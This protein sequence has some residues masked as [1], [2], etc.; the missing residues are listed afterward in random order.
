MLKPPLH[1]KDND[2][3]NIYRPVR[4]SCCPPCCCCPPGPQ[5]KQGLHGLPGEP[6]K[7]GA[8]GEQGPQGKQGPAGEPGPAGLPGTQGPQG[9][10]GY[11]GQ[12]GPPLTNEYC[13]LYALE[14]TLKNHDCV[15]FKVG[16]NSSAV[17]ISPDSKEI[18]M[19]YA[20]IYYIASAWSAAG[21]GALSMALYL[22]GKKIPNM[23]YIL[24][25]A[26][27][28]LTSCMP[29]WIILRLSAGDVLTVDNFGSE[30]T[31]MSPVNNTPAGSLPN[32]AATVTLIRLC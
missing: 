17:T 2:I 15:E 14:Q 16:I 3:M 4:G 6:G 11:K 30:C 18:I 5:G 23:N 7:S 28:S 8:Q 20:G 22:N 1:N 29:A 9:P 24:G 21:E 32:A 25:T 26:K 31:I 19:K 10:M 12:R 27:P 13:Y